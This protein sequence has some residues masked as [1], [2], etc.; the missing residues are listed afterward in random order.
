MDL[1][2]PGQCTCKGKKIINQRDDSGKQAASLSCVDCPDG[3][4]AGLKWEC[5]VCENYGMEYKE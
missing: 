1:S 4:F 2:V 5:K 3:Q